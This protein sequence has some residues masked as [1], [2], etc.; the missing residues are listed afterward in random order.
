MRISEEESL[1]VVVDVQERLLPVMTDPERLTDRIVRLIEGFGILELPM[2][3]TEQYPRGLGHTVERVAKA[4]ANAGGG[5]IIEKSAFSCCDES[6]FMDA[7]DR[8]G[9]RSIIL[10]GIESHVCMLQTTMDLVAKGYQPV[11][12]T[13]TTSSRFAEDK[14]TA[15]RR[16]DKEGGILTTSESL[17]FELT[18][19]TG[20]PRF[21]EISRLVK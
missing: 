4:Y 18:R 7:V 13:D 11:I 5:E 21:K 6:G 14:E 20:T 12:P 8:A 2:I 17:L 10:A 16:I 15:L 19:V 3:M 1:L 9:R